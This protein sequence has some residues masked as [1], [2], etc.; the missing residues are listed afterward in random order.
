MT[1]FLR[2][3]GWAALF[4]GAT[5]VSCGAND[6]T[7]NGT[8]GGSDATAT[9]ATATDSG[10]ELR[11]GPYGDCA[12]GAAGCAIAGSSCLADSTG[13]VCAPPCT[14]STECPLLPGSSMAPVCETVGSGQYCLVPCTNVPG[15]TCPTTMA[16]LFL[17]TQPQCA[18]AP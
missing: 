18:W 5:T 7:G 9:D 6:R 4:L 17:A 15:S 2:F 16:C 12:G 1:N 3:G 14:S 11:A 8:D 10:G 13:M